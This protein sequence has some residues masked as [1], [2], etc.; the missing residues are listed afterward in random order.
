LKKS[1][2]RFF[3]LLL[4][5]VFISSCSIEGKPK[6]RLSINPWPGY[7]PIVYAYEKGWLSKL[8]VRP[9]WTVSL[10]ESVKLY[11]AKL[12][13]GFFGTQFEY[14]STNEKD[15]SPIYFTN[16][17][18]GS[19][20]VMSNIDIAG[21]QKAD[22]I[23]VYLEPQ[24]VNMALFDLFCQKYGISGSKLDK[25]YK[26]QQDMLDIK[27]SNKSTIA[28]TYEPYAT[29]LEKMGLKRVASTANLDLKVVDALFVSNALIKEYKDE[30]SSMKAA[31][32]KAIAALKHNPKEFYE[33]V[34]KYLQGRSYEEFLKS[35]DGII[36]VDSSNIDSALKSMKQKQISTSELVK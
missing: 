20:V 1:V 13:D 31:N 35:L 28:V 32:D 34:K 33:T 7:M 9:L 25:V 26:N 8:E 2:I 29:L 27:I 36:W 6:L 15:L 16:L 30:L 10:D 5:A 24:S 21:L 3:L 17:S 11:D 18:N 4:A 19:D 23:S 14:I 22:R 12:I